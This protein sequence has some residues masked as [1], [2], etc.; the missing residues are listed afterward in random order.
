VK[1]TR[2]PH[3]K[4]QKFWEAGASLTTAEVS[5]ITRARKKWI[6]NLAGRRIVEPEIQDIGGP[7]NK[8]L[9]SWRNCLQIGL[10][11]VIAG[12]GFPMSDIRDVLDQVDKKDYWR[13]STRH[14]FLVVFLTDPFFDFIRLATRA[15]SKASP[16]ELE[17]LEHA[18][19]KAIHVL[20]YNP[21]KEL[22]TQ[23]AKDLGIRPQ[24][25]PDFGDEAVFNIPLGYP[26]GF[27][28]APGITLIDVNLIF[29]YLLD[30][31]GEL[32]ERKEL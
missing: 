7:G 3:K 25:P 10:A 28:D 14:A 1:I 17:K 16:K 31:A 27:P 2:V 13:L 11:R 12:M 29:R 5:K 24:K 23:L 18:G 32:R 9:Y 6:V 15:G 26:K 21:D 20:K 30:R 4:V 22:H 8:R 19:L